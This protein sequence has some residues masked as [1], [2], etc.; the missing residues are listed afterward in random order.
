MLPTDGSL[1]RGRSTSI[2][3]RLCSPHISGGWPAAGSQHAD[4]LASMLEPRLGQT[5]RWIKVSLNAPY[6][7]GHNKND[8]LSASCGQWTDL[9]RYLCCSFFLDL[10][11]FSHQF[12]FIITT[13]S[14]LIFILLITTPTL[15]ISNSN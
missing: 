15:H 11:Q 5:D 8:T 1:T 4:S 10:L 14:I 6:G 13:L 12:S 7:G 9:A 2:C 3:G